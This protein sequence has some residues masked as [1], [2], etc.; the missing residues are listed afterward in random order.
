M[1]NKQ[2]PGSL[3]KKYQK[4]KISINDEKY[5]CK[6][7][8]RGDHFYHWLFPQKSYKIKLNK[9]HLYR[10][11]NVY[12]LNIPKGSQL[13]S[14]NISYKIAKKM[15]LLAPESKMVLASINNEFPILYEVTEQLNECF[16]RKNCLMPVDLYYGENISK[17]VF[18]SVSNGKIYRQAGFWEKKS[19]SNYYEKDNFNALQS[20]LE[21]AIQLDFSSLNIKEYAIFSAFQTI[22]QSYHFDNIH[23]HRIIYD[24][25]KKQFSPIVWDPMGYL[26]PWVYGTNQINTEII[27]FEFF[28]KLFYNLDFRLKRH[29]AL[30]SYIKNQ[31]D[32]TD[33]IDQSISEINDL[34]KPLPT[35]RAMD[36]NGLPFEER[37]KIIQ[38]T[39]V[40]FYDI[41]DQINT[42]YNK[43]VPSNYTY[44]TD[45]NTLIMNVQG[46]IPIQKL[47]IKFS[48]NMNSNNKFKIWTINNQSDT[49]EVK[50]EKVEYINSTLKINCNLWGNISFQRKKSQNMTEKWTHYFP[51]ATYY[52]TFNKNIE[53]K[54]IKAQGL[55]NDP[56]YFNLIK[57]DSLEHYLNVNVF[58]E[59]NIPRGIFTDSNNVQYL[60]TPD[61]INGLVLDSTNNFQ[62]LVITKNASN[63][64][65]TNCRFSKG[66]G[67]IN[68]FHVY[69]GMVSVHEAKNVTF[70]NCVFENNKAFDDMVHIVYSAVTFDSCTFINSNMD[71]L[72]CDISE[73]TIKNCTFINSGNDALDLME[74]NATIQNCK[75]IGSKDKGISVG[76]N[77]KARVQQC[78]F[79]GNHIAI[80]SKD[81]SKAFVTESEFLKNEL[82]FHSYKKNWRYN[83]SGKIYYNKSAFNENKEFKVDSLGNAILKKE[84]VNFSDFDF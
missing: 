35:T 13:I 74:T 71:G 32:Y 23:N 77:S 70:K 29:F 63:S 1:V 45:N 8:L 69:T 28:R 65:F 41:T 38:K 37:T 17:D 84:K 27:H 39:K 33:I 54:N 6:I 18:L 61:N 57:N 80:E 49:I 78:Y 53:I 16:L 82:V 2:I 47:Q 56:Q 60:S 64:T 20:M 76:E 79:K 26:H 22:V 25:F 44:T 21:K 3:R 4:G 48:K 66:T 81:D 34:I 59:K 51:P 19:N 40:A 50:P 73:V 46:N 7:K 75:F 11:N 43:V 67:H 15:G 42:N 36:V 31:K 12:N 24:P 14:N 58:P 9:D 52:I 68:D 62:N 72:D 30:L 83:T 5:K 55:V 10:R